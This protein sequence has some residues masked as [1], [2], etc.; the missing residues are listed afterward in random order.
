MSVEVWMGTPNEMAKAA[1]KDTLP[2]AIKWAREH[3]DGLKQQAKKYDTAA[4]DSIISTSED[5]RKVYAL[6]KGESRGWQFPYI[7]VVFRV[8]L[9][10]TP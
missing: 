8:E 3:L 4:L 5:M 9:R 7:S 6:E 2:A 10:R 1:S